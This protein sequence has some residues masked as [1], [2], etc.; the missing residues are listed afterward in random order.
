VGNEDYYI[1]ADGYLMPV[2]K[3]QAPPDLRYFKRKLAPAPEW[4]SGACLAVVKGRALALRSVCQAVSAGNRVALE[5]ISSNDAQAGL[6]SSAAAHMVWAPTRGSWRHDL[7]LL[8]NSASSFSRTP[9]LPSGASLVLAR[10]SNDATNYFLILTNRVIEVRT[11]AWF[12]ARAEAPAAFARLPH[13][14][15]VAISI[16]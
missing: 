11:Q 1:S 6:Q 7:K 13:P 12:A 16:D 3:N 2:K 15:A 14:V 8:A 4:M 10:S 9:I 5:I